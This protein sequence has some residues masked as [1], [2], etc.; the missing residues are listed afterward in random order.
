MTS[1]RSGKW[2][3]LGVLLAVILM[4]GAF[5]AAC[6]A[7]NEEKPAESAAAPAAEQPDPMAKIKSILG[8]SQGDNPGAANVELTGNVLAV[9]YRFIPKNEETFQEDL[10]ED[11]AKKVRQI[12]EQDKN[13]DVINFVVDIPF[14]DETGG[15]AFKNKL[16]FTITRKIYEETDWTSYFDK[17][18]LKVVQDLRVLD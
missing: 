6:K 15:Q 1:F 8:E 9:S 2:V 10:G 11:L 16:T 18:F 17:D 7:K 4:L 3:S 13:I 14:V 5:S 12:Y